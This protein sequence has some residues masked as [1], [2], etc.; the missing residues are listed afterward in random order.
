VIVLGN[1]LTFGNMVLGSIAFLI[2]LF[3]TLQL[4]ISLMRIF[5]MLNTF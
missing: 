5:S 1:T 4:D 2:L 3:F